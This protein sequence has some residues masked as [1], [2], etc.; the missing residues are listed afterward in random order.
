MKYNVQYSD[1]KGST[2]I[3]TS[4]I[5]CLIKKQRKIFLSLYVRQ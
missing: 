4:N 3:T 2:V 5:D 1:N